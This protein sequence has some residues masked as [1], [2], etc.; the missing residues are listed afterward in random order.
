MVVNDKVKIFRE[1]EL[2]F[3]HLAK[4][5]LVNFVQV[6]NVFIV[7]QFQILLKIFYF[8]RCQFRQ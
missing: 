5:F 3:Q 2:I 1:I 8:Y 6:F 7:K 4:V